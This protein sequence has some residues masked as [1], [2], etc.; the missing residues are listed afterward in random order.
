MPDW[1]LYMVRCRDGSLYTG[2]AT[3][4]GPLK[5]V[6]KKQIGKKSRALKVERKV[7][8]LP[9]HKKEALIKTGA[10]IEA[11]LNDSKP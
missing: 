10:G 8:N 7:K 4:R 11:L 2:I 3:D 5:L 1:Y 9:R 6:F